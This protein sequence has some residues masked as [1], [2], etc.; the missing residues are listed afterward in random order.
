[1]LL[2]LA[3]TEIELTAFTSSVL[4]N[5]DRVMAAVCGV[6]PVEAA[7]R[8]MKLL[9]DHAAKIRHVVNFGI[10]GAYLPEA[11]SQALELLHVCLAESEVLGDHGVCFAGRV[12]S[13]ADSEMTNKTKFMLDKNLL[14]AARQELLDRAIDFSSGTFVTV[15]GASGTAERGIFLKNKFNGICENMEGAAIAR[16][17]EMYSLPM[18]E[19][20]VISNM[21][22]DR[23]GA[24][25]R[26]EEA[27]SR[28]GSI[29]A[30]LVDRLKERL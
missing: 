27:C 1:M 9:G 24:P 26:L 17:C 2:V 4:K 7:V 15:N 23:P 25:W 11:A 30:L 14:Y 21:V 28:A 18:L 8:A 6:G 13:F 12:E 20:R 29:A 22:E 3:A 16:C 5:D 19:V 10:G